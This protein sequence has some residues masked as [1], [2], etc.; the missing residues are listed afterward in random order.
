M[1]EEAL[2]EETL[3]EAEEEK[4][5]ANIGGEVEELARQEAENDGTL[6]S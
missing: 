4:E 5:N 1:S 3:E 2:D 6:R